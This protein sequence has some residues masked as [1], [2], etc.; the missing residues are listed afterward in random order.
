MLVKLHLSS[1][2][3]VKLQHGIIY[4]IYS[5]TGNAVRALIIW[6]QPVIL[7]LL[8]FFATLQHRIWN[9]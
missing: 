9:N 6:T 2:L 1:H 8:I 7:F 3:T 4:M 5:D